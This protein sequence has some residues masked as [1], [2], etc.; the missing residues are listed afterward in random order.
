M[1][2]RCISN[3]LNFILWEAGK[4]RRAREGDVF[5]IKAGAIPAK[6]AGL[7]IEE[8]PVKRKAKGVSKKVAVTNPE[9]G[10]PIKTF[11]DVEV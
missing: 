2:L 6:W 3:R 4:P 7:V 5:T 1:K 8:K 11:G 10:G 9:D